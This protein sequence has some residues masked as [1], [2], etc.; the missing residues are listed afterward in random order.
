MDKVVS[1]PDV[2][3]SSGNIVLKA[4]L[5]GKDYYSGDERLI[6]RGLSQSC[7]QLYSSYCSSI[8][9]LEHVDRVFDIHYRRFGTSNHRW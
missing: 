6:A 8:F 2:A 7:H 1:C 9:K 3:L 5:K 4:E